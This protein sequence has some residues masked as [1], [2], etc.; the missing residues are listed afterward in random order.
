M[1]T[2]QVPANKARQEAKI[3]KLLDVLGDWLRRAKRIQEVAKDNP[4]IQRLARRVCEL[5]CKF[6]D[7]TYKYFHKGRFCTFGTP[8]CEAK[9]KL[10]YW[11]IDRLGKAALD[12]PEDG[13]N[14][15]AEHIKSA[16]GELLE[17]SFMVLFEMVQEHK[18]EATEHRL[19]TEKRAE[20]KH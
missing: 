5:T 8:G 1:L 6:A 11:S 2:K 10:T 18:R 13:V 16:M 4:D 9:L 7:E 12:N 14:D 3:A 19:M 20:S 15:A 17:E